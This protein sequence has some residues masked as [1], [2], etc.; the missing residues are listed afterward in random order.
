M[1]FFRRFTF[2]RL[3]SE[4]VELFEEHMNTVRL[5][6]EVFLMA[7][8]TD[9]KGLLNQVCELEKK[10]DKIR[11]EIA[12]KLYSGAF[13]PAMRGT[14]YKLAEVIDEVLDMLEDTAVDYLRLNLHLDEEIRGMC[15]KVAKINVKMS[16]DLI[17]AFKN[18]KMGESLEKATV[19]IRARER[20]IDV[21]R[22]RI[23]E[24]LMGKDVKNYWE[25]K[26]LSDF[27]DSLV[28]VSDLIEDAADLI[29][30]L[31]VSLR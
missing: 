5:S 4:V 11:R 6:T 2:G 25:G 26:V 12:L 30:I 27:I 31:N 22:N 21:L 14:L 8:E 3:E 9:D 16:K 1:K 10:G 13:L 20:E 15:V 19:K 7:L 23:Y 29:Q 17:D 28:S 18:L 24:T